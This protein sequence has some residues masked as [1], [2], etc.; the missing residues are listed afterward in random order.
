MKKFARSATS[1]G[2][3][4]HHCEA[5][6]LHEVQHRSFVPRGAAMMLSWRSNDD[7]CV[8]RKRCCVLRTQMKKS[9][10]IGLD[11]LAGALGLEPRTNGFGVAQTAKKPCKIYRF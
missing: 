2:V 8:A 3:S 5:H 6:H 1:L 9:K 10:P 4:P 7:A 11:F